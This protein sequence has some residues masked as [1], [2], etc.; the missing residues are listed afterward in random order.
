MPF[1]F[2]L[3]V[4]AQLQ[5]LLLARDGN[6][7]GEKIMD[8]AEIVPIWE[9]YTLTIEEAAKYFQIGE[10][11]LRRLIENNPNENF[12]LCNGNRKLIKRRLFEDY[13]DLCA[14]I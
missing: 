5:I 6:V 12:I 9:K 3:T 11:K 7:K 8:V 2:S 10:T 14:V 1:G 4:T 13:I